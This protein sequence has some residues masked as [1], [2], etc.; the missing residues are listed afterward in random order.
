MPFFC[1]MKNGCPNIGSTAPSLRVPSGDDVDVDDEP[2]G[3]RL[4]DPHP[5]DTAATTASNTATVTVRPG[6]VI[7]SRRLVPW[8]RHPSRR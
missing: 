5:P 3:S 1:A 2:P 7:A 4:D 8:G 6:L